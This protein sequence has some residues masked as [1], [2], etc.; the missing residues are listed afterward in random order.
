MTLA[1][2]TKLGPYEIVSPLGAG[3]MGE[4][5][6]ATDSKLDR[7]VA[8][9]V[10]P[11]DVAS[12]PERLQRFEREA[13]TVAALNH[14]NIVTIFGI[15]ES[16]GHRFIAMELV[17]GQT[18]DRMVTPGGM[19]LAK[20]FDIAIPL[21]DALAAAHD[22]GIVHR[23]LKPANVMV[24]KE[25]RVKVLDFGLAKLTATRQ[26]GSSSDD[27]TMSAPLTQR[28]MIIGTV[29]Y[30]SPEQL[31]SDPLDHRTD[32]FS[33]GVMLYEMGTGQRPFKGEKSAEVMSS[34]LRDTPRPLH[35][36]NSILPR[37]LG[38]IIEHC[39]EKDP[40]QRFQSAKDVRN[41]LRALRKEVDSGSEFTEPVSVAT[42]AS[43]PPSSTSS[44][45]SGSAMSAPTRRGEFWIGVILLA[46]VILFV[47]LWIA[48]DDS[49]GR[50]E[51]TAEI[52][53][54]ISET[55]GKSVA[56]QE[57]PQLQLSPKRPA[58]AGIMLA[59][60]PFKNLGAP[61][62]EYFSDGVSDEIR[63][64]LARVRKLGVISRSS[65][66]QFRDSDKTNRQIGA[67]LGVA[68]LIDGTVRWDKGGDGAGRVRITP[69]LIRVS[70]DRSLW[71][72][73]YDRL[74]E[75]IFEIQSDIAGQVLKQLKIALLEPE[76]RVIEVKPTENSH[77][78]HAYL[79]GL[80]HMG[81]ADWSEEQ[82]R[83]ATQMFER[84]V[85]LDPSFALAYAQLSESHSAMHHFGYDPTEDRAAKAKSAVDRS[86]ELQPNLPEAHVALGWYHYWCHRNYDRALAAF[87][88]AQKG[89]PN[90][91]K[92]PEGLGYIRRRQGR[93][94]EATRYL[95]RAFELSPLSAVLANDI[96]DTYVLLRR[97]S[98]AE[99]WCDD[100]ISLVP[101]QSTTYG[102]K[103]N[104]YWLWHGDTD[105][106]RATLE[107][108]PGKQTPNSILSWFQQELLERRYQAALDRLAPTPNESFESQF[109]FIPKAQLG[110]L[111]HRLMGESERSREVYDTARILLEEEA[112]K[113]P[114]D[115]RIR[116]SLGIVYAGL[117]RK[118][119]AVREGKLGVELF[120]VSKDAYIGPYRE[121]DLAFIY[122]LIGEYDLALDKLKYLL[123]IP[124]ATMSVPM[125][126]LDPRWDPLR[127]HPRYNH[128]MRQHG[129][130][131]GSKPASTTKPRT[132]KTML[133]V[134]P[135]AN[136]SG[137]PEQE[138]FSD[139]MT[140]EMITR[141]GRLRP[142]LLGVIARTSAMRYKKTDKPI[143]QIG[144][145]L[146]VAYVIEG[147]VRRS[148]NSVRIN[149]QLIQVSDQT[150][151]WGD[152]YT[153]DLSDVFAIQA[154]VAEAVAKSLAMELLPDVRTAL[155]EA[156]T[157]DS[158]AHDAYLLGRHYWSRRTADDLETAITHFQRAIEIDPGY[159]LAYAGLSDVY[160]V[161]PGYKRVA[162]K[163]VMQKSRDAAQRALA[164]N[165]N[166]A[167]AQA[168]MGN[169]LF[170][171]SDYANALHHFR[172]AI[173]LNPNY[174]T[175][176]QWYSECLANMGHREESIQ[177]AR[178]A[179][180]LD[181]QSQVISYVLGLQLCP[182]AA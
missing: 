140:E 139:G 109:Q 147:G 30:M 154:E 46:V 2:G 53:V 32:L 36:L 143:D 172:K 97:Y 58:S 18:L 95:K 25:D 56:T 77:A 22:K 24:T 130:G 161:L 123:S 17:E 16:G 41:E 101:D 99:R 133:A 112:K 47:G 55:T 79:R 40:E 129:F 23:D 167:E 175:A 165:A 122:T 120:A 180:E 60:L 6:L 5:Y 33:L 168:A 52:A 110:G 78:Y 4:V 68:Y 144:R 20:I 65:A 179:V 105:M 81:K 28:G 82:Y 70:D 14:P 54:A 35:E 89:L 164:I 75:D 64:R 72:Q 151:L 10:L 92:I 27:V 71:S 48:R 166:L 136:L 126:R 103:A 124:S 88:I 67:E 76:R 50:N 66:F 44:I 178:I 148:G 177:Q 93:L 21:S 34:I 12:S 91:S 162:S 156:P 19:P 158:A 131:P 159:A 132:G 119:D 51:E 7:E 9:K 170:S 125:L 153:R 145:E 106:A 121:E 100:S 176:R 59:V 26:S 171:S 111:L 117:G 174:A 94:E 98:E 73:P 142:E 49:S 181:P 108:M 155:N 45:P 169:A 118:K 29:P 135:F 128:L 11:A 114:D 13:K 173:E 3:G 146:G 80:V 113:R 31:K 104:V 62:D 85:S 42:T 152:S 84:A 38:R 102:S 57:S 115:H 160:S 134:L 107:E 61:D 86:F 1:V 127:D 87:H 138:Y 37:H 141:L 69:E 15:E 116:S 43:Q 96:A 163:E 8:I 74:L 149:A 39:L 90:N 137:D 182:R 83:L 150:Q 157:D 63:S